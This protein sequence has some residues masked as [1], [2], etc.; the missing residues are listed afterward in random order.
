MSAWEWMFAVFAFLMLMA[1]FENLRI[2]LKRIADA[3]EKQER[4]K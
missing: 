3:L 4:Q 2:Q 1:A